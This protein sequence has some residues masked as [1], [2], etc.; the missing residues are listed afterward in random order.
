[1][2]EDLKT[3]SSYES[4]TGPKYANGKRIGI[5][6]VSSLARRSPK[7]SESVKSVIDKNDES[8]LE[9]NETLDDVAPTLFGYGDIDFDDCS[10]TEVI[11]FLQKFAK[12]PDVSRLNMAFTKHITNAL[13]KAREE[14]LQLETYIPRKLQDGW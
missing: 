1:M 13:I 8:G 5:G 10:I 6:E 9:D 11:K 14:K 4:P 3:L 2:H 12:S 7:S